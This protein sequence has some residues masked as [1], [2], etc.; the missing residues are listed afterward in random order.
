MVVLETGANQSVSW[1]E[2]LVLLGVGPSLSHGSW[3]NILTRNH[4]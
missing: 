4:Y 3:V 1:A 2:K